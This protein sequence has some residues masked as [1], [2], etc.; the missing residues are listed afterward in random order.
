[1]MFSHYNMT[2]F[3]ISTANTFLLPPKSFITPLH[4]TS[5]SKIANQQHIFSSYRSDM[6]WMETYNRFLVERHVS[7][8]VPLIRAPG[9]KF[10]QTH[11]NRKFAQAFGHVVSGY[12]AKGNEQTGSRWLMVERQTRP[13]LPSTWRNTSE[14]FA[15]KKE[16]YSE[17]Q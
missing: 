16:Y 17:I 14:N 15:E 2:Q 3:L 6:V 1:M 10:L 4:V 8:T 11:A 13:C 9:A 7:A 5:F 12:L